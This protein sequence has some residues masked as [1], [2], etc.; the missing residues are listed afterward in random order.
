MKSSRR[1]LETC[2]WVHYRS[3]WC[4]QSNRRTHSRLCPTKR[5]N[6][7]KHNEN[8]KKAKKGV[9]CFLGLS[10]VPFVYRPRLCWAKLHLPHSRISLKPSLSAASDNRTSAQMKLRPRT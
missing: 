1:T 10:F 8:H 4:E 6:H 5:P 3:V 7:N 2:E 9:L